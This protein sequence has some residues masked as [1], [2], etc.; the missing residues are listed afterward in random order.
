MWQCR[1]VPVTLPWLL[2]P[3]WQRW[4]S[5][6][7][8][9]AGKVHR[10]PQGS[11]YISLY[12]FT[13]TSSKDAG[14]RHGGQREQSVFWGLCSGQGDGI[15]PLGPSTIIG[16][17]IRPLP[18]PGLL[19]AWMSSPA[20]GQHSSGSAGAHPVVSQ[21]IPASASVQWAHSLLSAPVKQNV[22]TTSQSRQRWLSGDP[23]RVGDVF[24]VFTLL[25]A[26]EASRGPASVIAGHTGLCDPE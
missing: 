5:K 12:C 24:V 20:A 11:P 2:T 1:S 6:G 26:A 23:G 4:G 3:Q 7:N 13:A 14:T 15:G 25:L 21:V 18:Q 9:G 16:G 19:G 10:M 17:P 22:Q 8:R